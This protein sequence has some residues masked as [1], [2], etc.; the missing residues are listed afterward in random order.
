MVAYLILILACLI[1]N[2]I[3]YRKDLKALNAIS[4][5]AGLVGA[6]I[7]TILIDKTTSS[8]AGKYVYYVNG[9]KMSE[10]FLSVS[11]NFM[12]FFALAAITILV[13]LGLGYLIGVRLRKNDLQG[14]PSV[15]LF[16]LS[17]LAFVFGFSLLGSCITGF[18]YVYES[19]LT[20]NIIFTFVGAF[21]FT[22]GTV[23]II[24][25]IRGRHRYKKMQRENKQV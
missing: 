8:T 1:L 15:F 6:A 19:F 20:M 14:K 13:S 2:I 17:I 10:G 9:V 21:L 18:I 12:T 3:G 23:G 16:I 22:I 11:H 4:V 25:F 7:G 24:R 5:A